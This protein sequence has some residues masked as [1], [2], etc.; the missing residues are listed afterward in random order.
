MH[1]LIAVAKV[2]ISTPVQ[3][4]MAWRIV[5]ITQ[6]KKIPSVI[7]LFS[8]VSFSP[9]LKL[10]LM[11][12]MPHPPC[13]S[14]RCLGY[15][16]GRYLPT[17]LEERHV[18]VQSPGCDL[19]RRCCHGRYYHHYHPRVQSCEPDDYFKSSLANFQGFSGREGL[20]IRRHLL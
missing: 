13:Y 18:P 9:F 5:V 19:V 7:A 16:P 1:M 3:L 14:R 12:F 2:A 6:S 11:P 10:S 8:L 4:F 15:H 20:V 17:I